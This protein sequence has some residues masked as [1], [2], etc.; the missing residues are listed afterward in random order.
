MSRPLTISELN[1][2]AKTLLEGRLGYVQVTGEIT[3]LTQ[4]ASGHLYFSLKDESAQIQ[5]AFFKQARIKS[6]LPL[7]NGLQITA[8][9]QVS[10]YEARGNYQLIIRRVE[11]EGAGDL[12]KAFEALKKQL[13]EQGLFDQSFKQSI[14]KYPHKIGLITSPRGAAF[15][16][17]CHVL[18]RRAP[19]LSVTLIPTSVQGDDATQGIIS[20]LNKADQLDVDLLLLTRGG[21]SAEDLAVFN[22]AELAYCIHKLTTPIVTAIGHEI[23]TTIADYVSDI[24]APTPSAA[25]EIIAPEVTELQMDLDRFQQSFKYSIGVKLKNIQNELLFLTTSLKHPTDKINL[26]REKCARLKDQ[27]DASMKWA[28]QEK[29]LT[30]SRLVD[31][32]ESKSPLAVM[33]RGYSIAQTRQGKTVKSIQQIKEGDTLSLR[34]QDGSADVAVT[35]LHSD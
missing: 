14:P 12:Q 31:N 13:F 4:P 27:F 26:A 5:C 15:H 9:A 21:G 17:V 1:R 34:F 8:Y 24:R 29:Q 20:A 35:Q 30:F 10:L 19:Y 3:N 7:K 23:D 16:D 11:E 22:Q 18:Q 2:Q 33:A 6:P 28:L 32:L 25:A